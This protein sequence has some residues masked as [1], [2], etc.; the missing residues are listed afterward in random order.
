ML[1]K[2][3]VVLYIIGDECLEW[4]LVW[5][6][7]AVGNASCKYTNFASCNTTELMSS[8]PNLKGGVQLSVWN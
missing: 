2:T 8:F 4:I 1:I 3:P 6:A 7:L 5:I